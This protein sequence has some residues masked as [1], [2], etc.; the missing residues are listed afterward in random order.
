MSSILLDKIKIKITLCQQMK[1]KLK[2][3]KVSRGSV[4]SS[5]YSWD[6]IDYFISFCRRGN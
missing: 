1:E 5:P 3:N 2:Q 4:F 6:S